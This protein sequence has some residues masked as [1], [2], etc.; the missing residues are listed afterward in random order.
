MKLFIAEK[1]ELAI[2]IAVGLSGTN[3]DSLP[4][5]CGY[6]Q[7]GDNLI[8]WAFGHILELCEPHDY[9]A[10]WKE[11]DLTQLPLAIDNYKHKP[12]NDKKNQLKIIINLIRDKR[13]DSIVH[14]GDADDEGQ[15]LIDEILQYANNTKPVYRC[16]INDI[17]PDAVKKEISNMRPNSDF[18]NMS[19]RG[20]ARSIADW[21]VGINLTRAY[22]CANRKNGG[23]GVI[24]VGRVQTPILGLI[25]ER[26]K[27][28][29]SFKSK[30]Y[31]VLNACFLVNGIEIS[32]TLEYDDK[33]YDESIAL[34]ILKQ[35]QG[36][37]ALLSVKTSNKKEYPP[38]PYNLLVLQAEAS[39]LY[40]FSPSKTLEITQ[41]LREKY[42]AISYNRSDCQYL[43]VSIFTESKYIISALKQNFTSDVGQNNANLSIKSKAF[44][45]SKL[46]A[47]YGIIPTKNIVDLN[48]LTDDENAIYMLI[49]KRFLMQ[50]YEPREYTSYDLSFQIESYTFIKTINKT[51]KMGFKAFFQKSEQE[52]DNNEET[53]N[54]N[55]L[56]NNTESPIKNI[57][58]KTLQT[59]PRPRY[60]MTTLLKDL[61]QVSK[62]VKNEKIKKL[63]LEKDKDKKGESGGIGTPATRSTHIQTLIDRGYIEVSKDK[64]QNINAT[65]KGRSLVEAV[66][67]ML[68]T[69]DMTAFWFE[70]QKGIEQGNVSR[71]DFLKSVFN[72]IKVEIE[73]I[74]NSNFSIK[75][76]QNYQCP[77]CGK[78]LLKRKG[79]KGFFW[80]CSEFK[81]GCKFVAKD[82]N[83]KPVF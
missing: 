40:G 82:K 44:D 35:C 9:N 63:L 71:A 33:I 30:N 8:T 64:K 7:K 10:E 29:E 73:N 3:N 34:E 61:N 75:A 83:N 50:F 60:T 56:N 19:E 65:S 15:I 31:F 38:L 28:N 45:D 14:C 5:N 69:P 53:I 68:A 16:L 46:S 81:S 72:S 62:Y 2:A 32:A 22:T 27:E 39:K 74:K 48:M 49:C 41:S 55:L 47:H 79:S 24:S 11:W 13:V 76:T 26:D 58:I 20:F 70:Y 77:K 66:T 80:A 6:I 18:K 42:K 12:I 78:S 51:N 57:S 23:K 17:T 37:K 54:I 59:K 1:P 67:P 21:I 4:K 43:P 52:D 36:K 25:V